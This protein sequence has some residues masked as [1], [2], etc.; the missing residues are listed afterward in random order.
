M[1]IKLRRIDKDEEK[2]PIG[3]V[4]RHTVYLFPPPMETVLNGLKKHF[5]GF[6]YSLYAYRGK[7]LS[8]T[9]LRG[10]IPGNARVKEY[11][12]DE[13]KRMVSV[14]LDGEVVSPPE[15]FLK[16]AERQ[17]LKQFLPQFIQMYKPDPK[18]PCIIKYVDVDT[19]EEIP[20]EDDAIVTSFVITQIKWMDMNVPC[21]RI[22]VY[23]EQDG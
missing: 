14:Y 5:P 19:G 21:L 15:N 12:V 7:Y 23:R 13:E 10:V 22:S 20:F 1:L 4:S 18:F 17:Q 16:R 2:M 9:E 11:D 3:Q 8:P 6:E